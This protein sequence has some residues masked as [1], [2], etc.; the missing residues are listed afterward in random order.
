KEVFEA[1]M[2]YF[3]EKFGNPSSLHF[4]GQEALKAI[5]E[6]REKIKNI[7]KADFLREIIFTSSASESNNLALKGLVFYYYFVKK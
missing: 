3:Q 4:F 1:M 6:S 7:L 2:P 5:D